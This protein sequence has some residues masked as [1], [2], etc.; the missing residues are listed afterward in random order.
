MLIEYGMVAPIVLYNFKFWRILLV[1]VYS[2]NIS[3][4]FMFE[5]GMVAPI[6]LYNFKQGPVFSCHAHIHMVM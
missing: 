5:Y 2:C 3:V 6:G 4:Y 1:C